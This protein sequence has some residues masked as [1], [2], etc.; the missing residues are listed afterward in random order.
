[1]TDKDRQTTFA[2]TIG[3]KFNNLGF[4]QTAFTHRSYLNESRQGDLEQNE[5]LEFLGDAV[6]ELIVTQYLYQNF[7]NPEGEL[8][9]WRSAIVRGEVLSQVASDLKIG[10]QLY[11]SRG[12][13]RSGGRTRGLILANAFEALIGAIYL[14]RGYEE[15]A[16]FIDRFLLS[17]LDEIIEKKLYVDSKSH[18]QEL[19]QEKLNRTPSYAV[20]SEEGPD[21]FKQF[22][23]GVYVGEKLAA[24]GVGSSKQRAETAA[25]TEALKGWEEFVRRYQ[26][27]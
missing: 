9:N 5:R 27:K 26:H 8:T 14:D 3:V 24:Q 15:A 21:H 13:E 18:L 2:E 4:L 11:L 20:L 23:V 6:L 16:R 17:R 7:P 10:D 1:M 22:T 12:E 19:A 25:A